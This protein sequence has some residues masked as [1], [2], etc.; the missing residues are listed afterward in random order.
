MT[1]NQKK[2]IRYALIGIL[3]VVI[4][5]FGGNSQFV[6][7]YITD[8]S[9]D[10]VYLDNKT[11]QSNDVDN[12]NIV[13]GRITKVSD[14]DTVILTDDTGNRY[15]IR[16]NGIDCPEIEQDFGDEARRFVEEMV[17]DKT[18]LVD[19]VGTDTYDRKLGV[20]Y[21]DKIN[22]NEALLAN[23]LAW[24]YHYNQDSK[25]KQLQKEAKTH[26]K[27]I[28]SSSKPVDPYAWR[29]QNKQ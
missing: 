8:W 24:V 14:G 9:E 29:K 26:K 7:N 23:G 27:N 12:P 4:S 3:L 28:W 16:L 18:V 6:Q 10:V 21:V 2:Q 17:Q 13:K 20:L 15:K 19:V 25:Y 22:I 1:K 11:S 5:Y